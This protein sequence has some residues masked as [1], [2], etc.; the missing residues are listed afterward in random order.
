MSDKWFKYTF[1]CLKCDALYEIS[2]KASL[3]DCFD[4]ICSDMDCDGLLHLL[5]VAYATILPY[6]ERKTNANL[7]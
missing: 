1:L 3:P 5:S 6:N 7:V 4:P 2:S